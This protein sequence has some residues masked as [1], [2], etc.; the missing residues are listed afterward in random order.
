MSD[1][2]KDQPTSEPGQGKL[3]L[4][5]G[6]SG[7]IAGHC[8]VALLQRGYRVRGTL[9][10]LKREPEVRAWLDAALGR[11]SD[12]ALTFVAADLGADEGWPQAVADVHYVL[13]VAS[14]IPPTI[15]KDPEEIIGPARDGTLRVLRAAHAAGVKRVVQTSSTAAIT[16]G[17]DNP[18]DTVFTE[19]NWT[20]PAHRDN[21]PYTRSKVIA[22]RAAWDEMKKLGGTMQWVVI[23]PAL[24]L[25]PVMDRDASPSVA[26][27][28]KLMNGEIPG[29]PRFGFPIVDVRDLAE[30]HLIAMTHPA[31]DGQR[32]LGAGKF[33]WMEQIA[34]VLRT[35]L[36]SDAKKVP[37]R[38]LPNFAVKIASWFDP[39]VRG[40]LYELNK[41]RRASSAKAES[42]L[43]WK[44][45][46]VEDTIV[47]TARS[48]QKFH[49]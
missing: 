35:R 12:G 42:I 30:L 37:K 13:H 20:D 14:P 24:V 29:L 28:S 26:V 49:G 2:H 39:I 32:F 17:I 25:G 38:K 16:Y 18:N 31:A 5:T 34:D 23:N 15:P 19:D 4:V 41:V 27:V 43:G 8:I 45:R 10:S 33:M 36:G 48:L 7:Y 3:V 21:V 6:A 44:M 1:D 9:R 22:E 40:Q 47:D 46:P 11:V